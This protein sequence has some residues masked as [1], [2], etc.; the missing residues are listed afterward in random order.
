MF[1][2]DSQNITDIFTP[3]NQSRNNLEGSSQYYLARMSVSN[4]SSDKRR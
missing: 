2:A 3:A 1:E 4:R